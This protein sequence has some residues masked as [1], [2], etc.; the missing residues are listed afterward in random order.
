MKLVIAIIEPGK[1]GDLVESV[2]D[3][4]GRGLTVTALGAGSQPDGRRVTGRAASD[5]ADE[6]DPAL[7]R[8]IRLETVVR[9]GDA[10]AVVDAITKVASTGR[11]SDVRVWITPVYSEV[12]GGVGD[13]ADRE[14]APM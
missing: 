5:R 12:H 4:G 7:P 3:S 9:D 8:R 11:F 10:E 14:T 13:C 1:L 6:R 2:I